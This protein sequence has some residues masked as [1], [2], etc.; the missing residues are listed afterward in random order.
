[1]EPV[2][3]KR[4]QTTSCGACVYKLSEGEIYLLL[5]RP[6]KD[7][8]SWGVPKGHINEG[9]SVEDC[10]RREVF[11]ETGLYV[12][13]E[14]ELPVVST[15][16][17]NEHKRVITF[18]AK[19]MG[20]NFPYANDGENVDVKWFKSDELPTIHVYQRPLITKAIEMIRSKLGADSK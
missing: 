19:Q 20:D 15:K 16:F 12:N 9:E 10:A 5:V 8:D 11:E 14:D 7:R 6:F 2:T 17:K 18:L 3:S 4:K 1:M 13:L